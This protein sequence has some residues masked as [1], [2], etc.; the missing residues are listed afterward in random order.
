[1][2]FT[3]AAIVM[4]AASA[5]AFAPTVNRR[6]FVTAVSQSTTTE[7][8]GKSTKKAERLRFMQNKQFHRKGFKEVREGVETVMKEQFMSGLVNDMKT[9]QYVLE[10]DGV[11]VH[12]AKVR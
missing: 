12:L 5:S 9:G 10:R 8:D 6:A 7:E 4:L 2:K 1:M 11:K 3:S